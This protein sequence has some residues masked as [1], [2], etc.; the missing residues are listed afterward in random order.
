M[1]D[2]SYGYTP[3]EPPPQPPTQPSLEARP[4]LPQ[5][6]GYPPQYGP[7]Q[8]PYAPMPMQFAP[9]PKPS[10]MRSVLII[11]ITLVLVAGGGI[12]GY[13]LMDDSEDTGVVA[14]DVASTSAAEESDEPEESAAPAEMM[15]VESL[16]AEIPVPSENWELRAGPGDEGPDFKDMSSYVIQYEENWYANILVGNYAIEDLPFDPAEMSYLVNELTL[17]WANHAATGGANGSATDPQLIET[18]VGGRPAVIGEATATWDSHVSTT[19][20]SERVIT[21]LVDVD[22]INALYALAWIPESA[23]AEYEAV[24]TA[25]QSTTFTE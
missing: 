22:G 15:V 19:D 21:M 9:P 17:Y 12:A 14:D 8:S 24:M 10:P 5:P 18:M 16:G 13:L 7:P 2:P 25:L 3:G 1:T 4:N 6:P 23:D 11:A 20:T